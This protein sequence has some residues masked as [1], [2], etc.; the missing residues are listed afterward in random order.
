MLQ[1]QATASPCQ[2]S[3]IPDTADTKAQW[4]KQEW[5]F[6]VHRKEKEIKEEVRFNSTTKSR[7]TKIMCFD[8]FVSCPTPLTQYHG[9]L[10]QKNQTAMKDL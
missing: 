10:C 4:L 2:L 1:P 9:K 7:Q 8:T 6:C 5:E 3:K